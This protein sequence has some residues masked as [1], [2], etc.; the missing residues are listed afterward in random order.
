MRIIAS[1]ADLLV[2]PPYIPR[3]FESLQLCLVGLVEGEIASVCRTVRQFDRYWAIAAQT[4]GLVPLYSTSWD[5]HASLALASK[6]GLRQYAEDIRVRL[7]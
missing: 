3:H 2:D 7:K 4:A 1:H 5:N 6:L